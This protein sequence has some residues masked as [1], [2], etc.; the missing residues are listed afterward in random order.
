MYTHVN[1]QD[2]KKPHTHAHICTIHTKNNVKDTV[3]YFYLMTEYVF[4]QNEANTNDERK[5]KLYE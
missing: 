5:N 4:V 2:R 1:T 3:S